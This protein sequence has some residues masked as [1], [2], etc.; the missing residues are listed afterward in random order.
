MRPDASPQH[1]V[2]HDRPAM[3]APGSLA[4]ISGWFLTVYT[5]TNFAL[6]FATLMPAIFALAFKLQVIVPDS[7]TTALA[8]V[9]SVGAVASLVGAPLVGVLS[10][11]TTSRLGRRRPWIL[12]GIGLIAVGGAVIAVASTVPFVVAGWS[13]AAFG[14]A[15]LQAAIGPVIAEQVPEQQRGKVGALTGVAIQLAGVAAALVGSALTGSMLVLFVLPAAVLAIVSI[16][17]FIVIPDR[18]AR[19]ARDADRPTVLG[20]IAMLA[21]NPLKHRDFSLVWLG[22]FF[23]QV[24]TSIFAT[25]QLYFLIDRLG[26]TPENAGTQLAV[27]GGIGILVTTSMAVLAGVLSDRLRRR[28][29]FIYAVAVLAA[30]GFAVIAFAPSFT[31]YVTGTILVLAAAGMFG[32]V[33]LALAA[34]VLPDKADGAGRWIGTYHAATSLANVFSPLVAPLVLLLG[35]RG[36]NNYTALFLAATVAASLIALST[37]RIASVR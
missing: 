9:V 8:I 26:F 25:Y 6:S 31:F 36:A 37:S 20:A 27:V 19:F 12:A 18:P 2:E 35:A 1:P 16:V 34:D 29:P 32:S 23:F 22:K 10:D 28:K 4:T 15:A 24:S 30:A 21:F 33:D 13:V 17:Y 7:K 5:V 11:R 3:A 14:L